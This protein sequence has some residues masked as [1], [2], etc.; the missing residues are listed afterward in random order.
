MLIPYFGVSMTFLNSVDFFSWWY[1]LNFGLLQGQ[2]KSF[3]FYERIQTK[4]LSL[5]FAHIS[6]KNWLET[7]FENSFGYKFRFIITV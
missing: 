5:F 2:I 3:H 1:K 4:R 6:W 7:T